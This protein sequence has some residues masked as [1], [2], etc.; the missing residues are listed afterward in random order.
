M[1]ASRSMFSFFDPS[2]FV[3]NISV[4]STKVL[5]DASRW[6]DIPPTTTE[7]PKLLRPVDMSGQESSD[8]GHIEGA[9]P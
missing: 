4:P 5:Q 6:S 3:P 8:K 7:K 2:W 9:K 1:R